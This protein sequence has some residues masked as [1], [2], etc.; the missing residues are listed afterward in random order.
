MQ[1]IYLAI[2][3]HRNRKQYE[4]NRNNPLVVPSAGHR[5]TA[6]DQARSQSVSREVNQHN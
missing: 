2:D 3:I 6:P 1:A 4:E 5:V